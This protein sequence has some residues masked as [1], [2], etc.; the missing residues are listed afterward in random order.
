M[1]TPTGHEAFWRS[2]PLPAW[3][4]EVAEPPSTQPI[5]NTLP[6]IT[7]N[8]CD[9]NRALLTLDA[10]ALRLLIILDD[11]D[12]YPTRS[13]LWRM[14]RERTGHKTAGNRLNVSLGD[15][16]VRGLVRLVRAAGPSRYP[17]ITRWVVPVGGAQ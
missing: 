1:M 6:R 14:Y 10:I 4:A 11:C 7:N 9:S 8:D 5:T 15:L 17:S 16:E 3:A 12:E 2:E 13:E